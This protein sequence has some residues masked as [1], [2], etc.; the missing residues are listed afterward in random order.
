MKIIA[1]P[2]KGNVVDD[3]FGHCEH[4][5]LY[6]V[7]ENNIISDTEKLA[8]PQDCGCKSNIAGILK[9]KGVSV[10]LAGNMGNGAL[11]VLNKHGIRVFRGCQGE[12]GQLVETYLKGFVF[13]SGEGCNH[14]DD[15]SGEH[16][17]AH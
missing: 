1:I 3:H 6:T 10:M 4:Y 2:T 7:G 8:A 15:Q 11:Q 13:D 16:Q 9:E 17:C 5:T 12:V 14:H